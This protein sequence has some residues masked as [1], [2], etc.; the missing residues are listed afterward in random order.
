MEFPE[1]LAFVILYTAFFIAVVCNKT[2]LISSYKYS[3]AR[4]TSHEILLKIS[5]LAHSSATRLPGSCSL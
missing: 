1:T 5:V 4:T 2:M 3:N